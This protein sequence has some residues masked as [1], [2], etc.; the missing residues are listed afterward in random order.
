MGAGSDSTLPPDPPPPQADSVN[1]SP[2]AVEASHRF[3]IAY[4]RSTL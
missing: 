4:P 1:I 3:I 2:H